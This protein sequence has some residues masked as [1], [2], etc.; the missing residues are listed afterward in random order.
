MKVSPNIG[1]TLIDY[2]QKFAF[3]LYTI[4]CNYRCPACHSRPLIAQEGMDSAETLKLLRDYKNRDW[5]TGLVICGGEPTLHEDLGDFLGA[6]KREFNIPV[7]LD[8]NGSQPAALEKVIR[9]KLVDYVAMDIKGPP[10]LYPRIMGFEHESQLDIQ[11]AI[12]N[13]IRAIQLAPEYEFRTT[14]VPVFRDMNRQT[15]S[16][17]T[18]QEVLDMANWVAG[19]IKGDPEKV[20]W[21]VQK[22]RSRDKKDGAMVDERFAKD[23]LPRDYH[24]TPEKL[25]VDFREV[26]KTQFPK[27]E[28]R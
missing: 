18:S 28:L 26:L 24:E 7:K 11:P 4:G 19:L 23:N 6:F 8:T 5:I 20:K 1:I 17:M 3:E 21:Y 2:P 15:Y 14:A 10:Q 25:L 22:F 12:E 16:W 27:A 9:E 13:S